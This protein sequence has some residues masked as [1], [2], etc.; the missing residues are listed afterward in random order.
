MTEK[1]TKIVTLE[2]FQEILDDS[3]EQNLKERIA[4]LNLEYIDLSD[5]EW[6]EREM[7]IQN[8]IDNPKTDAS[9]EHRLAVWEKGWGANLEA[10]KANQSNSLVPG[11]FEKQQ[12]YVAW[13]NRLVR[14]ITPNFSYHILGINVRWLLQKYGRSAKAI[15]EFG[16]G[17][18]HHLIQ[19]REINPTA[20][21]YGLDWAEASQGIIKEMVE[22]GMLSNA[23]GK[24]F[25]F[26]NPDYGI[27]I[28]PGSMVYTIAA[29][30]QVGTKHGKFIEY[31][32]KSKP[33]ICCHIEPIPEALDPSNP[34]DRW[35]VAYYEK[36][37]YLSGFLDGLKELEKNGVLKIE[38]VRRTYVGNFFEGYTL[39]VWRPV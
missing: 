39:I 26:F 22:K 11:Y 23:S 14:P 20:S 29:L 4:N 21:L 15:Y 24:R 3:L 33:E 27:K 36:R 28:E 32:L 34:L 9:G 7:W 13:R 31:L 5:E 37:N 17:T 25:D 38:K 12:D 6:K 1:N 16:C 8:L 2:D 19:A 18:G 30:E 10:L 35:S